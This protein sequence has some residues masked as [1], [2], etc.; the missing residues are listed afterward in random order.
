LEKLPIP[1]TVGFVYSENPHN[2]DEYMT[3]EWRKWKG[4]RRV[5]IVHNYIDMNPGGELDEAEDV[6]PYEEWSAE[7]RVEMLRH[8]PSLFAAAETQTRKFIARILESE[9]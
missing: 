5:C 6:T 8:I 3:L 2:P 7:Q 1:C 9:A 4:K